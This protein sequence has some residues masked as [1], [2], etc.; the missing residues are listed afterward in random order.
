MKPAY[1]Q[2][3]PSPLDT[4]FDKPKEY[5][6]PE[7]GAL[8]LCLI[9]AHEKAWGIFDTKTGAAVCIDCRDKARS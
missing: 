6:L 5:P 8:L 1:S 7:S 9:C 2:S 4:L 3:G